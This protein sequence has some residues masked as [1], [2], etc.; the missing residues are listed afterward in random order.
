[1]DYQEDKEALF[2]AFDSLNMILPVVTAIVK[3]LRLNPDKLKAAL[4]PDML[5]TDLAD[6]LARK[7]LPFRQAHHVA[8]AAVRKAGEKGVELGDLMLEELQGLSPLFEADVRD[9]FDFE[10]SVARRDAIG[11]TEPEA[12]KAQIA[13][14]KQLVVG[15]IGG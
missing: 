12:V 7:G 1:K 6:Y 8:A 11:G 5:A 2:D 13:A 3:T 4:D 10:A 15:E 14:A 9:V